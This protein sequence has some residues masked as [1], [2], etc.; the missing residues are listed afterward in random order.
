MMRVLKMTITVLGASVVLLLIALFTYAASVRSRADD[1]I[2]DLNS[3]SA[4][5]NPERGFELLRRKYGSEISES[6]ASVHCFY[7][8]RVDNHFLAS[9]RLADYAEMTAGVQIDGGSISFV[10][11]DYRVALRKQASPVVHVQEDYCRDKCEDWFALGVNPHGQRSLDLDNG[12]VEFNA[13]ASTQERAAARSFNFHCFSFFT[14]CGD[15]TRLL[16]GVWTRNPDGSVRCRFRTSGDAA[17]D[18]R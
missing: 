3:M 12:M 17:D 8:I 5:D 2:N 1:I 14:S 7:Q 18:W 16:P 4:A 13:N 9:L 6:C 11:T 15:I 10:A